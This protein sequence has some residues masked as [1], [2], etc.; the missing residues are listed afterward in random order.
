[1]TGLTRRL[2]T[3]FFS[4][5]P[6][7]LHVVIA[8]FLAVPL[9]LYPLL[10]FYQ[11]RLLFFPRSL[12]PAVKRTVEE[13]YPHAVVRLTAADGTLLQGWLVNRSVGDHRWP[14]LIYWGGNAE[15]VS[16]FVLEEGS[17]WPGWAVM[18]VNYR[19]YGESG[20]QPG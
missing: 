5:L 16:G 6:P 12:L 18:A 8:L 3:A 14:L 2:M 19:G 9:L 15:E 10:Y 1:M 20:G 11:E 13:R 17:R 7:V 4:L